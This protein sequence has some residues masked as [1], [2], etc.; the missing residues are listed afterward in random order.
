M[1]ITFDNGT[2]KDFGIITVDRYSGEI[3]AV[4]SSLYKAPASGI[5][6]A[7]MIFE[8][9]GCGKFYTTEF[10]V[11]ES[12]DFIIKDNAL[13]RQLITIAPSNY[14]YDLDLEYLEEIAIVDTEDERTLLV[15]YRPDEGETDYYE[16]LYGNEPI[17]IF[18]DISDIYW[19]PGDSLLPERWHDNRF[20]PCDN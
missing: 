11:S 13:I 7:A 20:W 2:K 4:E 17:S 6:P 16:G 5:S 18:R 8:I 1:L 3:L 14:Y 9:P 15:T 12:G 10:T 19:I